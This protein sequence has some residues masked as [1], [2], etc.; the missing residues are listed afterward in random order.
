MSAISRTTL[1]TEI[2]SYNLRNALDLIL[3][4]LS[5]PF[6]DKRAKDNIHKK[7]PVEEL[8]IAIQEL[9]NRERELQAAVGISKMLLDRNNDLNQKQKQLRNKKHFYKE[10][11]KQYKQ[12][13]ENLKEQNI[14]IIERYQK[15]NSALV[16]A[17]NDYNK[18][19][20]ENKSNSLSQGNLKIESNYMDE[21]EINEMKN[22]YQEDYDYFISNYYKEIKIENE[23]K[24]KNLEENFK[25][26]ENEK[27]LLE[28]TVSKLE[29]NLSRALTKFK[30][31]E[32]ASRELELLKSDLE[33]KN[34]EL[35]LINLRLR[36]QNEKLSEDIKVCQFPIE[37]SSST[38]KQHLRRVVSL[39]SELETIGETSEVIGEVSS[40]CHS[41]TLSRN[42][43]EIK[44][45]DAGLT[46]NVSNLSVKKEK[47]ENQ[48]TEDFTLVTPI[49]TTQASR[50]DDTCMDAFFI[51]SLNVLYEKALCFIIFS[52]PLYERVL[53]INIRLNK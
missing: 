6:L 44:P 48:S 38:K 46:Q 52:N 9:T 45:L 15:I 41:Y 23:K 3:V 18:L 16:K 33:E 4:D 20:I 50:S 11:I 24:I 53:K 37:R 14:I 7:S 36:A 29:R 32:N 47:I 34:R 5:V 43:V 30:D 8:N 17:E 35:T 12:D 22:K 49:Q 26:S 1:E 13:I 28:K 2:E 25:K 51:I 19:L 21:N 27:H 40:S 39:K 10:S 31:Q 42:P